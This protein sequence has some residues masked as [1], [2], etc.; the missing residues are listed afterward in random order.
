MD[1][2]PD[3]AN[4]E[5]HIMQTFTPTR[6]SPALTHPAA[7]SALKRL[8][9]SCETLTTELLQL[10]S[11]HA[12]LLDALKTGEQTAIEQ[13]TGT[14]LETLDTYWRTKSAQGQSRRKLFTTLF[15]KALRDEV[16]LK[17]H[18]NDLLPNA[19]ECLPGSL[20]T[21]AQDQPTVCAL[22]IAIDAHA[23]AEIHGALVMSLASGR[24]LLALPGSGV[25]EFATQ[26]SMLDTVAH[27]LND[28]ALRWGLLINAEQRH[29]DA[30]FA[31]TDDPDVYLE[32]FDSNDVQLRLVTG[33]PY[34]HAI[35]RLIEKQRADVLYVCGEGRNPDSTLHANQIEGAVSLS[36]VSGPRAM[37]E[38]RELTLAERKARTALPD[39]IKLASGEDLDEYR[40]RLK[41]FE[42][43][44]TALASALNGAASAEQYAKVSLRAR[45]A[46][47]LGYD[48]APESITVSTRRTLPVTRETYTVT[49]TLPELALYGLHP[50]DLSEGSE[51]LTHTTVNIDGSPVGATHALLTPAYVAR[52]IDELKLR[53]SFAEYQREAYGK[54]AS[55]K[56]MR[57]LLDLQIAESAYVAKMQGHLSLDDFNVVTAVTEGVLTATDQ[58]LRIQHIR[59]NNRATLSRTLVFRK[60]NAAGELQ[61]LIMFAS[62]APRPQ[63]FQSFNSETQLL[64]ELVA[65]TASPE[66]TRYLIDQLNVADRPAL[67]S[68]LDALRE[69]P[70]PRA[71]FLRL[72]TQESYDNALQTLVIQ[73]MNVVRSQNEAHTPNWYIRASSEQRQ[74]L[75]ALE[76]AANGAITNYAAQP[77]TRVQD[78][79]DYVHQRASEKICQ[80]LKVPAG[81]VDPDH[82][83]VKTERE[84][85]SYTA[86]MRNGYD[87]SFGVF[88]PTADT[89]ATFS[90]PQGIDL[91]PLTPASV[92][93]SV[94]GKWLADAYRDLVKR[95]LLDPQSE[96]YGYRRQ[97]RALITRLN[98]QAAALR[99]LLKG[100]IDETQYEWL[101]Q[102]IRH[103]NDATPEVRAHH[104]VYPLQI[105]IDKPFIALHMGGISQ[106]VVTDTNL[107]HI[108][109][110]QGCYALMPT[111]V[112]LAALLYTPN[113]PDGLEFRAFSSFVDSL[114]APGM[115][116]YYKD[117]CRINARRVLS[118]FLNDMKTGNGNKRPVLPAEPI[119]DFAQV[120]FNRK[121]ERKLRDAEETSTN[122]HDML[123]QVI[124]NSVDIIATVVTAPF[125]P[126]SFA[127]GVALALRDASKAVQALAGHEP[128]T[129]S[130]LFLAAGLNLLG[131]YGDLKQGLKGFGGVA[132]KLAERS[133][134]GAR[135]AALKKPSH[136]RMKLHPVKLEDEHFLLGP[137]NAKGQAQVYD[138]AGFEPDDAFPTGHYASKNDDGVWQPLDQPSAS[139][140]SSAVNDY[141]VTGVSLQD[142][143]RVTEGHANGV[144]LGQGKHY[145]EMNGEVYQVHYDASLHCWH[146]VDPQ[147]PFAFFGR[148]PVRLNEQGQWQRISRSGLRGGN[149]TPGTFN[150][151]REDTHAGTPDAGLQAWELPANLQPHMEEILTGTSMDPVAL[152]LE[153]FFAAYYGDM[154]RTYSELRE[155]LYRDARA[156]F[157]E[158][159]ALPARPALPA[160]DASTTVGDFL[161][162][163]FANSNG[164]VFG[165]APKSI[166]SKR[167]L[168]TNM[169]PLAEQRVE[170]LYIEH[171]FTDKHLR[172]LAKYRVKGS[173]VRAGS[174]EIKAHLRYLNNKALDNMSREFD[175]YHL[176]KE[177][178]RHGIEVRPL[179]SSVSYPVMA[180]PVS[181]A[182][183]DSAAAQKMSNFFGHKVIGS[184]AA[185]EPTRRW[186]ALVD[187]KLA[188]THEHVLGIAEL[189][190]AI[191]VRIEDV[192]AGRAT[193]ISQEATLVN[194]E[195][196][197]ASSDFKIEFPSS[198]LAEP[199]TAPVIAASPPAAIPQSSGAHASGAS[200]G[201]QW[202]EA[203]GWQHID[204]EQWLPETPPT[205]LQQSLADPRYDMPFE[206][207]AILYEL[208]YKEHR[209]L[210]SEYFFFNEHLNDVE[211]VFF[212]L[213]TK[214]R[215]DAREIL[216]ADLPPRPTMPSVEPALSAPQFIQRLYEHTDGMVVGEFHASVGSKKFLIDNLS[217]LAEQQV[218]T[219]YMEHLLTDLHQLHLDRFHETGQMSNELLNSLQ[220]LDRGQLTDPAKAYNFEM[221]VIKAREHGI[222]VRA[223]DCAASYHLKG[224]RETKTTRQE[225]MNYF[226]SRT[227]RRHQAVVGRHRWVALVGNSH[228]NRY[229][230]VPGVAELEGAIGVRVDDVA[231]GTSQGIVRD[232]GES[233]RA[234]MT[235]AN[236]FVKGD[237]KLE[238]EV[239][240]RINQ[241]SPTRILAPQPL[242][243]E[244]RLAR[245]GMFVTEL[246]LDDVYVIVHRTRTGEI[247]RT[248]VQVDEAGKVFV[249]RPAWPAVHLQ[250]YDDLDALILALEDINLTRVG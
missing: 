136:T 188:T 63:L 141:R 170:V 182:A 110:V 56:L 11:P 13:E 126:L 94:R 87:D 105:H 180:F 172:K 229:N 164:L 28:N 223:I 197:M 106:L 238:V 91:S 40:Q 174:H 35:Q 202:D 98:M 210:N 111:A 219:L 135:P 113:A 207:H 204:P 53:L 18:E 225:M 220:H 203:T 90:G 37:L 39:W 186:V 185:A 41:R 76:D 33:N 7:A 161:E 9:E 148:Q 195:T 44:H 145:I 77:H 83:I 93:G 217:L 200:L 239:P 104:P 59:I 246:E 108:E 166:A 30:L 183:G 4:Q 233:A 71:D 162:S 27:W 75:L 122:R 92:A 125:P 61:R 132:R 34:R 99:S 51:F 196:N 215:H 78:F 179:N 118:F 138:N 156:F 109:T 242:S 32:P 142:L 42:D 150:P 54:P 235:R 101:Q 55:Q 89:T 81:T 155:T 88:K 130:G 49:R 26:R 159:I 250:P 221:L 82:I 123:S 244:Q 193:K 24:T 119:A 70:F 69:K 240:G 124:W 248:P 151:L 65:W 213:R 178:H 152:G 214:L 168:M 73:G 36:G 211:D 227:I 245:P 236:A 167:L 114:G 72:V 241:V 121:I 48:L 52:V 199:A 29:Q 184:D 31:A 85:L 173:R 131:A 228:S 154:R 1:A 80:L 15:E 117:R 96:G 115:I 153:D 234:S 189:E 201:F 62:D 216:T 237:F 103:L 205:A 149:D 66:M 171:V 79:E 46:S 43:G 60:E 19:L 181:G 45:L 38:R 20:D 25:S 97:T 10:S 95:T 23:L 47:D 198:S 127:V 68:T 165:E 208:A 6:P 5:P 74:Q 128:E 134:Q 14:L 17:S 230:R 226:A 16:A 192:P 107:I 222:E 194:T 191:S 133:K 147:N 120:C 100:H 8:T 163:V 57:E 187:Q 247:L 249:D 232:P 143:P 102:S 158:P 64:H 139:S 206:S 86:M 176:I 50:N 3:R 224:V 146:I 67:Y 2:L 58:V 157:A 129:A 190:G 144:S 243:L 218:K 84:A 175:Y 112:R 12:A 231:P 212:G 116:D 160:V 137:P 140:P 209:G 169:K 21:D 177:A 22:H